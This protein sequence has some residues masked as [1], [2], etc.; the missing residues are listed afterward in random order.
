M[1]KHVWALKFVIRGFK[2]VSG[3]GVKFYKS[4]LITINQSQHFLLKEENFL[5]CR[6][7]EKVFSFLGILVG[8]NTR[9]ISSWSQLIAKLKRRL[10]SWTCRSLNLGGRITLLKFVLCIISVFQLSFYR[11]PLAICKEIIKIQNLFLWGGTEDKTRI[12]WIGWN[13]IF[14]PLERG[15]GLKQLDEFNVALLSKWKWRI[16]QG[17]YSLWFKILKAR[18]EKLNLSILSGSRPNSTSTF[19]KS[20]WWNNICSLGK[21][22]Q[23]DIFACCRFLLGK[24]FVIL[25]WHADTMGKGPLKDLFSAIFE[26]TSSKKNMVAGSEILMDCKLE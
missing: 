14:R 8:S 20:T 15:L 7:E 4:K 23:G 6:I 16:L 3:L 11:P 18:Y 2:I 17:N 24:G 19:S 12:H 9:C 22:L 5:R 26:A 21:R 10:S 25:C 13:Y 1:W